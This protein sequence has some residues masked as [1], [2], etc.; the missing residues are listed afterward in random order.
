[1]AS[2]SV[3]PGRVLWEGRPKE[4]RS[5][6]MAR[7]VGDLAYGLGIVSMAFAVVRGVSLLDWSPSTLVFAMLSVTLGA[8]VH[9]VPTWWLSGG[10]Y[11]VT[12]NH[13]IWFRGPFKRSIERQAIS[14][15]RI[16]WSN[17]S[18]NIGT[19]ELIRAVPTGALRR[20]L[21]LRLEGVECPDGVWAIIRDAHDVAAAGHGA[22]P[23]SQRLDV[24]E[25]IL[26]AARPLP[27]LRAYLPASFNQWSLA[28][29]TLGLFA[30]G[31]AMSV[32]SISILERLTSAGFARQRVAF[33]A[34]SLGMGLAV[35]FVFVVGFFLIQNTLVYR[36][37]MLHQTRYLIS[38][39]R[40]LIQRGREELHLD[41]RIIVEIIETPA[42]AGT[43]NLFLVL[44]GPRA[45]AVASSGAFGERT[46]H[47]IEL[48]P[49]FECVQDGD[50]A[51]LAL[52]RR[53][54]SLPPVPW[55]A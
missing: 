6:P 17:R 4:I 38:N 41:R 29:V 26:W 30:L 12:D 51:R 35:L 50:G 20:R 48:L 9:G 27:T 40:V 44:D 47:T 15:A 33:A 25:R 45:R 5:S 1:M 3:Y 24:G 31:T 28:I 54:P 19:L 52:G 22:L 11:R 16:L 14:Y 13:V 37:R 23:L 32:R 39:K 49:V 53:S 21:A 55:A 42:G 34:L 8:A 43:R 18:A 36:A 46:D 7:L 10:A 2:E